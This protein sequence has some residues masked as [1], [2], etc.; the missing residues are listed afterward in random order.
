MT[1]ASPLTPE[2]RHT[3][4]HYRYAYQGSHQGRSK[5][6]RLI[7]L[8]LGPPEREE[9]V[10]IAIA[11]HIASGI[12]STLP[13][14][15]K[16][17]FSIHGCPTMLVLWVLYRLGRSWS[18]GDIVLGAARLA[19]LA[20]YPVHETSSPGASAG[21]VAD[22]RSAVCRTL[23]PGRWNVDHMGHVD[24]IGHSGTSLR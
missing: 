14:G 17:P 5:T 16:G 10:A 19:L 4:T 1:K 21:D 23:R 12:G 22:R 2:V 13:G 3:H 6:D 20:R 18:S 9:E 11:E 8:N 15:S 24:E 7:E